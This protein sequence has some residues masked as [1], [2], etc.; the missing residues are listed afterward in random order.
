[1]A[2]VGRLFVAISPPEAA[3]HAL[4][5]RLHAAFSERPVPGS[6]VDPGRWHI[7]LRFLGDVGEVGR[8][9]VL[10]AL[11]EADL[12]A[13]RRVAL[14]G[15]G[16][17]PRPD[18]A[19]VL[20]VGV[21][22]TPQ[23]RDLVERVEDAC[24]AAGVEPEGRP[25]VGHLTISRMRPAVDVWPWLEADVD[26]EVAWTTDAVTLLASHRRP[27]GLVYETVEEFRLG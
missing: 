23:L 22:E 9:R 6:H 27:A 5:A 11:D 2:G 24:T 14:G 19:N 21:D 8:D 13:P 3:V 10:A 4:A 26:L 16:A 20:W 7:T 1:M 12:G 18:R 17:F 15:L 25:F